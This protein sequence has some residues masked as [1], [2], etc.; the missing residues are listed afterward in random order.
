M[1]NVTVSRSLTR[2]ANTTTYAAGDVVGSLLT[3]DGLPILQ[4]EGGLIESAVFIDGA[5]VAV[6][7]DLELFLFSA[8]LSDLD[9]DNAPW[10]PTDAQLATLV[11]VIPFAGV[12]FKI[13]DA[14]AGVGG[15]QACVVNSLGIAFKGDVLYGVLVV[16]NAYVPVSGEV[17]TVVLSVIR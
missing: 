14:T 2:P 7:P 4:N 8:T 5:Y 15:N 9:A 13:G 10:T 6:A 11:G 1:N 12:T 16:R 17:F 3:F